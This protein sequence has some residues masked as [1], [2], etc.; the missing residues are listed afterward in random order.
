MSRY[1]RICFIY[2]LIPNCS[3][4]KISFSH[5]NWIKTVNYFQLLVVIITIILTSFYGNY[6]RKFILSYEKTIFTSV[7]IKRYT[8][9]LLLILFITYLVELKS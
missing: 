6:K 3:I 4:H 5:H 9:Y 1:G 8:F 2:F 7:T